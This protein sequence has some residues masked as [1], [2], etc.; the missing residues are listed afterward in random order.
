M[1]LREV[2]PFTEKQWE[3]VQKMS[4]EGPTPESKRIRK[5]ALKRAAQIKDDF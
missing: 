1:A 3:Q 5:E 4:K 2:K